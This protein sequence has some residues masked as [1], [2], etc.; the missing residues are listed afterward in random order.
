MEGFIMSSS[1]VINTNVRAL[2][3]NRNLRA[4]GNTQDKASKRLSSG[5]KINSAADDAAGLAIS[6]KMKAQIRG[7][8]MASKNTQ[9]ATS[10]VETIEG[11]TGEVQ[12][13]V[14]RIRE[15]SVQSA[16]DTNEASD[17]A[18]IQTEVTGLLT[19]ITEMAGRAEFNKQSVGADGLTFNFQ[20]GANDGGGDGQLISLTTVGIDAASLG[21]DSVDVSDQ[22]GSIAALSAADAA[23]ET[24]SEYRATLGALQ[25]RLEYT[26]NSLETAS[27]N[28][29]SANSRIE[30][31]DMAAEMTNLTSANVINQ[32][33]V[34]MLA[35]ANQAPQTVLQLLS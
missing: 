18:K 32:A 35:Q 12:N 30:D 27:E 29:S 15:L 7:L 26:N 31:A 6:Q 8:D 13:M 11:Y 24:V 19:E 33:A 22:A 17:R 5:K 2:N 34:S 9:D 16:N 3:S 23:L 28:L 4:V 21:I 25:N 14:Q 1:T 20:V 10:M